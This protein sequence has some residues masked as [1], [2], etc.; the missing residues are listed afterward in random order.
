M[1]RSTCIDLA[2]TNHNVYLTFQGLGSPHNALAPRGPS[3]PWASCTMVISAGLF[4]N[5]TTTIPDNGLQTMVWS[6][7]RHYRNVTPIQSAGSW[8]YLREL[9]Y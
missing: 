8:Q 9:I 1:D 7:K 2:Q 5:A 4:L 6:D 3:S